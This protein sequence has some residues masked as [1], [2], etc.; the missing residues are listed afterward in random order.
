MDKKEKIELGKFQPPKLPLP[1]IATTFIGPALVAI[2]PGVFSGEVPWTI[3]IIAAL[4]LLSVMLL[5][6]VF[7]VLLKAYDEAFTNQMIKSVAE[8]HA[9]R[10]VIMEKKLNELETEQRAM[11]DKLLPVLQEAASSPQK[12]L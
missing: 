8:G 5:V 6:L 12:R 1:L 9:E 7:I 4:S 11:S 10:L 3:R 2:L